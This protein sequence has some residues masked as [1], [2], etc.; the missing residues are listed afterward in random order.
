MFD[1]F[2]SMEEEDEINSYTGQ[3]QTGFMPGQTRNPHKFTATPQNSGMMQLEQALL[4]NMGT[5]NPLATGAPMVPGIAKPEEAKDVPNKYGILVDEMLSNN[6]QIPQHS[7][8][9][10]RA[11]QLGEAGGQLLRMWAMGGF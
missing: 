10:N 11:A 3:V 6:Q 2:D 4:P 8:K 1:I 9:G 5:P 7:G